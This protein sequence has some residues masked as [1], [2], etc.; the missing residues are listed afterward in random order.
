MPIPYC[1]TRHG[2]N[3]GQVL[4]ASLTHGTVLSVWQLLQAFGILNVSVASG[5]MNW[6]VWLRTLTSAMVC[7]IFGM[8]QA[9]HSLPAEPAR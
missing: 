3:S 7:S 9:T 2:E 5:G 1:A 6:N 8:W 4:S